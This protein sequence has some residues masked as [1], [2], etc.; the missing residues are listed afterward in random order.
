[1]LLCTLAK[2]E[3]KLNFFPFDQV[4]NHFASLGALK[5]SNF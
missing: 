2:N 5:K 4:K 1:M 3:E